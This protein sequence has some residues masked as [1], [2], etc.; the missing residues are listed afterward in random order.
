M[1]SGIGPEG[2]FEE[3]YLSRDWRFYKGMLSR[4]VATSEPGPILDLGAGCGYLVET[5][6][7]WGLECVGLEGSDN[8]VKIARQRCPE[9]DIR[10]FLLSEPLPFKCNYFSTVIMNQVIEH[11]EPSVANSC[12]SEVFR[13]LRPGGA[14]IVFSPSRFNKCEKLEDPTHIHMYSPGELRSFLSSKGLT[15][16][17]PEDSPLPLLGNSRL[18]RFLMSVLFRVTRWE[19]LSS[20]ANCIAYKPRKSVRET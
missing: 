15:G 17:L 6:H 12:I 3:F 11:L 19:R 10:Q 7:R 2:Y 4:I 5:I 8:A 14:L 16:I 13:V 1:N 20:S 18:G 9:I